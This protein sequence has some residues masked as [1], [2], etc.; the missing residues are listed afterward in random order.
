MP[1]T[2]ITIEDVLGEFSLQEQQ[3]LI[4]QNAVGAL[5]GFIRKAV[6]SARGSMIAGGAPLGPP[7]TLPESLI[8]DVIGVIR[9]R[10]LSSAPGLEQFKSKE[11]ADLYRDGRAALKDVSAGQLKVELPDAA[12]TTNETAVSPVNQIEMASRSTR[13]TTHNVNGRTCSRLN[14]LL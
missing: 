3:S 8:P 13:A 2:Q 12:E 1:W 4:G 10:W 11:R 14:G 6:N 7:G 5:D 9:W